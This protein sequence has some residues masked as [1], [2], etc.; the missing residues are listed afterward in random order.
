MEN[1]FDELTE[2]GFRRICLSQAAEHHDVSSQMSWDLI[3]LPRLECRGVIIAHTALTSLAQVILLPQ[4]PK[5]LGLQ[6]HTTIRSLALLSR[7]ECSGVISAHC[8]L[9]LLGS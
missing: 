6:A 9:H 4:P 1:E 8:N 2:A 3:L 5:K 7:L